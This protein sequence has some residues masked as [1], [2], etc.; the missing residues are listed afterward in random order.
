[1]KKVYTVG[2]LRKVIKESVSKNEFRAVY[3]NGVQSDNKRINSQAYK[4][5]EKQTKQYDGGLSSKSSKNKSGAITPTE[6]RGM[7]DIEYDRIT[8]DFK[9]RVKSQIKGYTSADAEKK[10]KNDPFGNAYFDSDDETEFFAKHA[11]EAKSEKDKL[12]R[13]GLTGNTRDKKEVEGETD[14]MF[15]SKKLKNIKF[16][17]TNFLSEG[18]MISKIPDEF[19]KE[20][21]K[22]LM[23]D[24]EGNSYLVEW[25]N[26]DKPDIEKQVNKKLVNEEINRIKNLYNYNSEN[27][28]KN[29][30][31]KS[32]FTENKE[33]SDMLNKARKIVK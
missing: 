33:V 27:Y 2:E 28:F 13:T 11:K 6:N 9:K 18:H 24:S 19:K 7:S 32:R 14:T 26:N 10:H 17:H 29:T 5:I 15:E 31:A 1:M 12:K 22:F 8:P 30:T 3:G 25:H 4:D 20:G 23:S 16:R 21:N